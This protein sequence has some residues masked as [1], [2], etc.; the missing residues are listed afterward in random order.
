M[1]PEATLLCVNSVFVAF[2]FLWVYPRL[3]ERR[4]H[5]MLRYDIAITGAAMTVAG[6]LY[7]GKGLGFTFLDLPWWAFSLLSLAAL[8]IPAW[9]LF[10]NTNGVDEE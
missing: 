4:L 6:L 8:E 3:A 10:L 1:S 7:G 2:A 5:L 9:I